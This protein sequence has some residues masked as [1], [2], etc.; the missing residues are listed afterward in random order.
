MKY[1]INKQKCVGCQI[2]LQACPGATKMGADGK[3]E[4]IDQEKLEK[5][6]GE[7]VC[8]I[9]AIEEVKKSEK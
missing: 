1:R 2:C 8:P 3:A 4:I 7:S 9:G 5:C 6:G